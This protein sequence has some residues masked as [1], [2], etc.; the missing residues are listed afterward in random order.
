[1]VFGVLALLTAELVQLA[2][3]RAAS[4]VPPRVQAVILPEWK[5]GVYGWFDEQG[6][7]VTGLAA[8]TSLNDLRTR[9]YGRGSRIMLERGDIIGSIDG[10]RVPDLERFRAALNEADDPENIRLR[11]IDVRTGRVLTFYAAAIPAW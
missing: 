9:P 11:V 5:L 10:R 7:H 8:D 6:L 3:A 4:A 2:P 1:V